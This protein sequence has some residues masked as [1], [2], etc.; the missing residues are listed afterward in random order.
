MIIQS[1]TAVHCELIDGN[2]V[3]VISGQSFDRRKLIV[4]DAVAHFNS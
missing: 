2:K 1:G 4:Y 3:R